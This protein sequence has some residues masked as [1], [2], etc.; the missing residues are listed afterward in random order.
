MVFAH[1]LTVTNRTEHYAIQNRE[2]RWS[3][4][5]DFCY[6]DTPLTELAGKT[7]GIVGLGNIGKR[8]AEIALAFGLK[9]KALTSKTAD[10]LPAGIEKATMEQLLAAADIVSLH[11]PLTD[12]TRHMINA[13]TLRLM[14]PTAVLINTGRGPLVSD[15]D[16]AKALETG[17]I[18]AYCADVVTEEPPKADNPL[19]SQPHAYLTP[20]I[21]WATREARIRLL[22]IAVS[23]VK[24]WMEQ[25]PQ[26][27][28]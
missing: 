3:R 18:A 5:P 24:A 16:V 4:N 17:T 7:F 26:N 10:A 27:M 20:H 15:A 25:R 9:V 8:V 12:T 13:E 11:C 23:N 28:V 1:L 21:A 19:L 2:G 14:K 6:W 22:D